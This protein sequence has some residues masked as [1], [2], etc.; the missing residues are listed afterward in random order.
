MQHRIHLFFGRHHGGRG[1]GHF[2][3]VFM[4]DEMGGL[5]FGMGRKLASVDL[6]LLI[7]GLLAEKPRHGYEIIK[8]LDER[9]KGFYIPSPGM[10][11]PALT[12]LEES[13][14][15]QSRSTAPASS[16]TSPTPVRSTWTTIAARR[17]RCLRNSAESANAWIG[18]VVRCTPKKPPPST[19]AVAQRNCCGP[20]TS[21]K[22]LSPTNGIPRARNNSAS[23]IS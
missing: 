8:A 18:Y 17:T 2:G 11:Y 23:S 6:Q 15:P 5:A 21:L 7:L 4:G 3:R 22:Q 19:S 16:T 14:M 9:S 10:V 13:G 1:F 12:Y 20:S